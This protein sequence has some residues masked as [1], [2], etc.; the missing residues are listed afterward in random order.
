[1]LPGPWPKKGGYQLVFPKP[2]GFLCHPGSHYPR[3]FHTRPW[4]EALSW[5]LTNSLPTSRR[6]ALLFTWYPEVQPLECFPMPTLPGKLLLVPLGASTHFCASAHPSW[7]L[8]CTPVISL[9]VCSHRRLDPKLYLWLMPA[10]TGFSSW[11][12]PQSLALHCGSENTRATEQEW[13]LQEP[14]PSSVRQGALNG[15]QCCQ[16]TEQELGKE[17]VECPEGPAHPE[18]KLGSSERRTW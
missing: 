18:G 15:L 17:E 14:G 5:G 13:E 2:K 1:M 6:E 12:P 16:S 10:P 11:C 4:Y 8:T 3:A 9:C 7:M